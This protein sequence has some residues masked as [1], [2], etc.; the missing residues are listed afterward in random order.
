[1]QGGPYVNSR[2]FEYKDALLIKDTLFVSP[3]VSNLIDIIMADSRIKS[4]MKNKFIHREISSLNIKRA[5]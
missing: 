3:I 5:M 1:M 4:N 2:V